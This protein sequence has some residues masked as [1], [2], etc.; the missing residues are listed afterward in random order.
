M[1][2]N[3]QQKPRPS[4]P[5]RPNP[6]RPHPCSVV[7]AKVPGCNACDAPVPPPAAAKSVAKPKQLYTCTGCG[8]TINNV[9][10]PD[11]DVATKKCPCVENA[12]QKIDVSALLAAAQDT[13]TYTK[14]QRKAFAKQAGAYKLKFVGGL[15]G[16]CAPC[17]TTPDLLGQVYA[18]PGGLASVC[19]PV[20]P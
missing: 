10:A 15:A 7:K 13:A 16:A 3:Q 8:S 12:G 18:A 9:Y 2:N 11:Y 4:P 6:H 1:T 19:A 14:E 5:T 17:P 20:P